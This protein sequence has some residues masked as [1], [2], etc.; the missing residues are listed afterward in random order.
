VTQF[1]AKELFLNAKIKV[2]QPEKLTSDS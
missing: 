1:I 2:K